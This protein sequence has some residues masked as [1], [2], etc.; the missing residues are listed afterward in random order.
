MKPESG[1]SGIRG[2]ALRWEIDALLARFESEPEHTRHVA[3]LALSLF[4]ALRP[5]HGLG[6]EDR[7][8][9]EAAA[10]LHDVGWAVT[11]PDG[12]GHHRESARLIREHRWTALEPGQIERVALVARYHRKTLPTTDHEEFA[13]LSEGD[14]RRVRWLASLVRIADGLD[15]RH[16]QRV[17]SVRVWV[18]DDELR[19]LPT[20]E[21]KIEEEVEAAL[22]KADLL[23]ELWPGPVVVVAAE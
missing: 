2:D 14:Q 10:T 19:V 4:D 8:L 22:K 6:A 17:Q 20:G 3:S 18:G 13:A 23:R 1:E 5:I 7:W 16:V 9:L 21:G 12:K 15:R 11:Q